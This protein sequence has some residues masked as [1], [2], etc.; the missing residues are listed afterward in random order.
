MLTLDF[1]R[2]AYFT[3]GVTGS[4]GSVQ[5]VRCERAFKTFS[6]GELQQRLVVMIA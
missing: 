5:F 3:L 4:T 6:G 1:V 2:V